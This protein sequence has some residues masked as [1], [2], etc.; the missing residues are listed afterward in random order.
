MHFTGTI[1][2][3]PF[4]ASAALIQVTAGC[5]HDHCKFCTLYEGIKFRMS[6]MDEIIEDLA[7]TKQCYPNAQRA[8]LTGAN[9][10]VLHFDKLKAIALKVKEYLPEAKS[11]GCFSRITDFKNKTDEQLRELKE[12]GYDGLNIGVES[13]HEPTLEFMRKGYD[14]CDI[15][16]QCK[17]LDNAGIS[18]NFFY[19]TG[20][21]GAGKGIESALASAEV[22]N[23][24]HP[25]I[26]IVTAL[27]IFPESDLYLDI[28][29]GD[30]ETAGEFEKLHEL[31]TL[32]QN[33]NIEIAIMADTISNVAPMRGLLPRDKQK[34]VSHLQ[35][36]IDNTDENELE[37]YREGIYHL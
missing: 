1:W 10:F 3:P 2:R 11:I 7:E 33:L 27:T 28:Q 14:S 5:T 24:L 19:L 22:F 13:G 26:L 34:M 6:P 12:L 35:G 9:P 36:I 4:E 8:Y 29:S 30:Y 20:L 21:A 15:V 17:R 16:E 25:K 18:Y 23:Q 32:Y 31:K 37:Q